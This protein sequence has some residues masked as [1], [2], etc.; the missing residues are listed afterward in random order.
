MNKKGI[1]A[2]IGIVIALVVLIVFGGIYYAYN[3][4]QKSI[5]ANAIAEL[6]RQLE[7]QGELTSEQ[8]R[9][10]EDLA[11]VTCKEVQVPYDAQESY[12]EQEPYSSEECESVSLA[13]NQM[14]NYCN[15][16]KDNFFADNE[17]A[18]YSVTI[19][20]L[21]SEKGGLFIADIGFTISGQTVTESQQKYIYPDSSETFYVERMANI[22][23]CYF[24]M[25]S[26]PE[27]QTCKTVTKYQTVTKYRTV[28]KYKTETVCE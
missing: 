24:I 21:D 22:D 19:N 23:G 13:Y 10:L 16:Y 1:D 18:K 25:T 8:E 4:N 20:N 27:K 14:S 28:T 12:T 2:V 3:Q 26:V 7:E 11:K 5:T 9:K 6:E 17:P 15:N